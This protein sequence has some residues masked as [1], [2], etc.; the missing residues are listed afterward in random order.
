MSH[1]YIEDDKTR[2][3]RLGVQNFIKCEAFGQ[4]KQRGKQIVTGC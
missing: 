1:F 4:A 3:I 2:G